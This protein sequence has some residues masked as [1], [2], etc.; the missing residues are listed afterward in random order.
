MCKPKIVCGF[1]SYLFG[2][3]FLIPSILVV[4]LGFNQWYM[5]MRNDAKGGD[6]LLGVFAMYDWTSAGFHT[7]KNIKSWDPTDENLFAQFILKLLSMRATFQ[8][9]KVKYTVTIIPAAATL[10]IGIVLLVIGTGCC[11]CCTSGS[12][13]EDLD[14]IYRGP[15][16]RGPGYEY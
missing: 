16:G 9:S 10:S 12:D 13:E 11:V 15:H 6:T 4:G 8:N 3:L 7:E 2:L 5:F 1:C 14:L